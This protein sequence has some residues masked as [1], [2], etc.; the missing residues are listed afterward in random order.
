MIT[1]TDPAIAAGT[2]LIDPA[3]ST[4]RFRVTHSFGLGPVSGTFDIRDGVLT[5]ADDPGGSTVRAR[6]DAGSFRTDKPR[7]DA[8][9]R[10]RRFLDADTFPTLDFRS[11]ALARTD[12]GWQLRGDLTVRGVTAP[13]TLRLDGAEPLDGAAG[14]VA[15]G[16]RLRAAVRVDRYRYRVGPRGVIARWLDADLD[17]VA[18]P[19]LADG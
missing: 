14:P 10:G 2:Y 19:A 17:L 9:V 16:W 5:V 1:D 8:D 15:G 6:V 12:D 11:A 4:V 7:R 3:H 18:V 13:V